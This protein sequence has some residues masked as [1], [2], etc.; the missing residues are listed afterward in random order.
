MRKMITRTI[1][2][3]TIQSAILGFKEGKPVLTE[4]LPITVN[5]TL[6]N[7]K[8]TKEVRKVY[9]ENAVVSEVVA[10]NSTYEISVE[11]FIKYSTKIEEPTVEGV[12]SPVQADE[13]PA[14]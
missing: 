13:T 12:D 3:T 1:T 5:G 9:G 8:A 4:N 11:D 7:E 2:A 14:E 10:T 6:D